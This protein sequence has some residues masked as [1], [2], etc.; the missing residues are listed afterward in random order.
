MSIERNTQ[1]NNG[2]RGNEIKDRARIVAQ[3]ALNILDDHPRAASRVIATIA[4]GGTLALSFLLSTENPLS[5]I[6]GGIVGTIV[7]KLVREYE[8]R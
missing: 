3:T 7:Y 1:P 2:E 6:P 5:I 4:G 8:H